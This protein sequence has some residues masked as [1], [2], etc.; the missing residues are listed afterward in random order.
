[1]L[2]LIHIWS[3][4]FRF[5]SIGK[6]TPQ[7]GNIFPAGLI[8]FNSR[9]HQKRMFL[10]DWTRIEFLQSTFKHRQANILANWPQNDN[11]GKGS[12]QKTA[13][14]KTYAKYLYPYLP[15][16][17]VWTD[18]SLDIFSILCPTYLF[19]KFGQIW[20]KV[21]TFNMAFRHI[22]ISNFWPM[23][24]CQSPF[25][26]LWRVW[27]P[28]TKFECLSLVITLNWGSN[29]DKEEFIPKHINIAYHP[30]ILGGV[31]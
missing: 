6:F 15:C 12:P 7:F 20:K 24:V 18:K 25:L 23:S 13:K 2:K 5:T 1:M 9:L 19:R 26:A 27:V 4:V 8:G 17:L 16:T 30:E 21:F 3:N 31:F 22:H 29:G 14:F 10:Q 11:K 28:G